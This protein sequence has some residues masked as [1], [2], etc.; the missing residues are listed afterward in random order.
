MQPQPALWSHNNCIIS[1]KLKRQSKVLLLITDEA[2]CTF[3]WEKDFQLVYATLTNEH[4]AC[5]LMAPTCTTS[6]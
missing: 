1:Q 6:E 2:H 5:P 4:L 3:E